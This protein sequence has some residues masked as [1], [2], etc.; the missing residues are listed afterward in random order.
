MPKP[1]Q[2]RQH[3]LDGVIAKYLTAATPQSV[4]SSKVVKVASIDET[5]SE[6][7]PV[8]L[9]A[10]VRAAQMKSEHFAALCRGE[11]EGR[12]TSQSEADLALSSKL[13]KIT[14]GDQDLADRLFRQSGLNR[15]KWERRQDYRKRTLELAAIRSAF[16]F[17]LTNDAVLYIDSDPEKEPLKICGRLEVAAFTR[18]A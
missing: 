7:I 11:W 9:A 2:P 3:E 1:I 5:P 6:N 12:Y 8:W 18:D 4:G 15:E 14:D 17:R 16:S 10:G 13:L